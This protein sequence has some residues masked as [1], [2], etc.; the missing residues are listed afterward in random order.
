MHS[1][2][3][4]TK[5]LASTSLFEL[6]LFYMSHSVT[7]VLAWPIFVPCDRLCKRPIDSTVSRHTT[8]FLVTYLTL[9]FD[10]SFFAPFH[11][12]R[13]HHCKLANNCPRIMVCSC[14]VSPSESFFLQI[15]FCS[16]AFETRL[17]GEK[18]PIATLSR[19]G[20]SQIIVHQIFSLG[21]DWTKRLT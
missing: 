18:W 8:S 2:T 4:K 21:L 20:L 5:Q 9:S 16:C 11:W 7:C 14:V 15:I 12:P 6:P 17:S 19:T 1:G 3:S 10:A 13:A